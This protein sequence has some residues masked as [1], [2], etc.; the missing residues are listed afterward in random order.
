MVPKWDQEL[1]QEWIPYQHKIGYHKGPEMDPEVLE[2]HCNG[3]A[4]LKGDGTAWQPE[5]DGDLLPPLLGSGASS[6]KALQIT[7]GRVGS[8]KDTHRLYTLGPK[9]G[10]G[11]H[12]RQEIHGQGKSY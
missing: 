9:H 1:C 4:N 12:T 8:E 7:L 5:S 2:P 6:G 10:G 3:L 11:G